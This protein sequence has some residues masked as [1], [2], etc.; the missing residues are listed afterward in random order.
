MD[1]SPDEV[2]EML[3]DSL[4]TPLGVAGNG[5]TLKLTTEVLYPASNKMR[6]LLDDR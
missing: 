4:S 5:S 6:P 2:R 1:T 3:N